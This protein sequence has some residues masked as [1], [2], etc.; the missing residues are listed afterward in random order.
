M[1]R[2][3]TIQVDDELLRQAQK[4]LGTKGLKETVD[5][6]FEEAIRRDLRDRLARRIETGTGV[7]RSPELLAE[8]RPTR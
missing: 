2:R 8:S 6:A 3:T 5:R 1:T 7:D 4:A